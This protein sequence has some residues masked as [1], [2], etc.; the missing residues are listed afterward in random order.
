MPTSLRLHR[1]ALL[2]VLALCLPLAARAGQAP[3][4][5]GSDAS[6]R[7]KA[8]QL[9]TLLH[10]ERTV[11]QS[12]DSIM[13]QVTTEAQNEVGPNPTP[14]NKAKLADFEKKITQLVEPQLGWRAIQPMLT[15]LYAKAFTEQQLDAI[16]AFY[17]TPAGIALLN[18]V[19]A[20]DAQAT[21][22]ANSRLDALRPQMSQMFI[23]FR[24]SLVASAPPPPV[25]SPAAAPAPAASKP[26]ASK[27][28]PAAAPTTSAPK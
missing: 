8:A 22:L 24:T 18:N 23:D 15:G 14:E 6:H 12:F 4:A 11:Q 9:V 7:A 20:I 16:L 17:K 25:A 3:A 26:A 27:P 10:S 1:L 28:A 13:Q 19:P 5:R 2:L 21:Q